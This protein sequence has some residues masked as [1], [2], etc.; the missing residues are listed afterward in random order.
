LPESAL[1]EG[2][3]QIAMKPDESPPGNE[4]ARFLICVW[5]EKEEAAVRFLLLD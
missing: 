5:E 4:V 3:Q 2:N 1:T